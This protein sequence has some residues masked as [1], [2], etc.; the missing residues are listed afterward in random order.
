MC[1]CDVEVKG[2]PFASSQAKPLSNPYRCWRVGD[3]WWQQ[4][5]FNKMIKYFALN[6][7]KEE[8]TN[9]KKNSQTSKPWWSLTY[10]QY[11]IG[12]WK[13]FWGTCFMCKSIFVF[14]RSPP[15]F[16]SLLFSLFFIFILRGQ[17]FYSTSSIGMQVNTNFWY[18]MLQ[19]SGF[20]SLPIPI[21]NGTASQMHHHPNWCTRFSLFQPIL[22]C[23]IL[24]FFFF[25]CYFSLQNNLLYTYVE[26]RAWSNS[27]NCP[28]SG[29]QPKCS[30]ERAELATN[31]WTIFQTKLERRER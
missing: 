7:K 6:E 31:L 5:Q 13:S 27:P 12:N 14:W 24:L 1:R 11:Q 21:R 17:Y 28:N 10:G 16:S 9:W 8:R 3:R 18:Q 30:N 22:H 29:A 20:L 15:F 4:L 26:F 19:S 23:F 2:H 25:F